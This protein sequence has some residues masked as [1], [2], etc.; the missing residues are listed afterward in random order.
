MFMG[1]FVGIAFLAMMASFLM[2]KILSSASKDSTRYQMLRK[3]GVRR[4]LLTQ[5]IY[6]E[7][8][9]IF[10]VTAIV[11]IVHILVGMNMFAPLLI[12][13]YFRIWLPLVIFVVIY[14]IYYLITVQ[15]YKRILLPKED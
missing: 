9:F 2:F 1:F 7:L 11:G 12:D 10:L 13:P 6:K 5:S 4:G 8:F 15:L 3:I 14:L